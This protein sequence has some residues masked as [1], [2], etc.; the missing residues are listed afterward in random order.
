MWLH[1]YI[2]LCMVAV[3]RRRTHYQRAGKWGILQK[4]LGT[5]LTIIPELPHSRTPGVAQRKG[6]YSNTNTCNQFQLHSTI[7]QRIRTCTSSFV[8][9]KVYWYFVYRPKGAYG[10][11]IQYERS[12]RWKLGQFR[13]L[14]QS[15]ALPGHVKINVTRENL[16]EDSF[17][18]VKFILWH[19]SN[20]YLSS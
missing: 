10:V 17:Q 8:C 1:L 18:Q 15:N 19:V 7:I 9:T 14:C 3:P 13:Y 2:I 12:F 16:F 20:C 4:V 5:L 6:T 11:P